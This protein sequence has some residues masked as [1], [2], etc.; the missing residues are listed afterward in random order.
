[1]LKK[2][3]PSVDKIELGGIFNEKNKI[4]SE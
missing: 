1:L 2:S 3:R 4:E